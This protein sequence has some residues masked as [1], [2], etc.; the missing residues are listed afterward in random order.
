[1]SKIRRLPS[2]IALRKLRIAARDASW[3]CAS[4]PK[5]AASVRCAK[6]RSS[7]VKAI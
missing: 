3:R 1:M 5:Q 2:G 4:E 7:S 6:A